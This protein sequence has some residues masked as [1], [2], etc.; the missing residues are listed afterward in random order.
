MKSLETLAKLSRIVTLIRDPT[1]TATQ[2]S[3]AAELKC[4][5]RMCRYYFDILTAL[6]APLINHGR[7][8]WELG[9]DDWDFWTALQNYCENLE[10]AE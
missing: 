8:G 7:F 4:S 10:K 3:I 5:D 9:V 6:G 1:F 2:T